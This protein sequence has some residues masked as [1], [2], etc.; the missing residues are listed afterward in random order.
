M[1]KKI[2]I[3]AIV[4][5]II[6]II[7][8]A[9]LLIYQSIPIV[10]EPIIKEPINGELCFV[11]GCSKELCTEELDVISTCEFLPGAN[12]LQEQNTLCA[13]VNGECQWILSE[14]SALC[15][16]RIK[17]EQ[18]LEVTETRIKNL[19]EQAEKMLQ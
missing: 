19:F 15:F 3:F 1:S 17:E 10:Q 4:S 16:M 8:L 7:I 9:G 5:V 11:G 2:I 12:C 6:S 13:R 14:A 18:G